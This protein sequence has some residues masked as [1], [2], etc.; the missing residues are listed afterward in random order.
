MRKII[1]ITSILAIIFSGCSQK[2]VYF[3]EKKVGST[4]PLNVESI[5]NIGDSLYEEFDYISTPIANLVYR[6]D[7]SYYLGKISIAETDTLI[8]VIV[9]D[10]V[11]Y[12]SQMKTYI[13]PLVGPYDSVCF[14][15]NTKSNEFTEV[16]VPLIMLGTW[17]KLETP[18]PYKEVLLNVSTKGLKKELLY[19]GSYKGEL[20]IQY[21]EYLN[22][23]ARPAFYQDVSY[24]LHAGDN[25]VYIKG[26]N[27]LFFGNEKNQIHYKV[28]SGFKKQ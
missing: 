5:A 9:G 17:N 28:L 2:V 22:D 6:I 13:D 15:A 11:Q 24:E 26:V 18:I 1:F 23:F 10:E 19:N 4:P 16:R 12:C 14:K 7:K 21:R 3:T 25:E 27:L 20:K 8:K